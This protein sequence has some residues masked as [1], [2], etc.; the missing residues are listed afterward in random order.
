M[1]MQ[2]FGAPWLHYFR[3]QRYPLF[4]CRKFNF[5]LLSSKEF[6]KLLAMFN[7]KVNLLPHTRNPLN[8]CHYIRYCMVILSQCPIIPSQWTG[9]PSQW[10]KIPSQWTEGSQACRGRGFLQDQPRIHL[11]ELIHYMFKKKL[12][13]DTFKMAKNK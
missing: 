7:L 4:F 5:R 12:K 8:S 10:T 13:T 9:I 6:L 3:R 2:V 1:G 11:S